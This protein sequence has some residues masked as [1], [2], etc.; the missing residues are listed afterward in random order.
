MLIN[1]KLKTQSLLNFRLINPN[2]YKTPTIEY[3]MHFANII[4]LKFISCSF[5]NLFPQNLPTYLIGVPIFGIILH[6]QF[7]LLF[8]IKF[9]KIILLRSFKYIYHFLHWIVLLSTRYTI[10]YFPES[11]S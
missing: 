4:F 5:S 1:T 6:S 11:P 2:I 8:H 3:I 9:I 10:I 7:P